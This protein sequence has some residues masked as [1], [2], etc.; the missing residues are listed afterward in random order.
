LA[1][2]KFN[3]DQLGIVNDAVALA[4]ELVSNH[5]K[6]ANMHWR[7]RTYDVN[8]V[9][10]LAPDEIV[11]GPYAQVIRF[12]GRQRDAQLSSGTFDFFKICLQD[13]AILNTMARQPQLQLAPFV[14]YIMTHE[15][16]HIVR[17]S[18]FLQNFEASA[19]ERM[20]EERRVHKTTHD[21]LHPLK[22]GGLEAVLGFYAQWRDDF[23]DLRP[24]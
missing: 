17:F 16:V 20:E 24:H 1:R 7:G 12:E 6:L 13:H 18:L 21:I 9:A 14:L 11:D 10:E 22:I 4:E 23:D 15:L 5:Y 19:A 3:S 2:V 8:T